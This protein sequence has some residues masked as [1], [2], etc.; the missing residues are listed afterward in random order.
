MASRTDTAATVRI[1][2][3]ASQPIDSMMQRE[4]RS[5]AL[6]FEIVGEHMLK[7]TVT[8]DQLRTL[9]G[10]EWLERVD[11]DPEYKFDSMLRS[12]IVSMR[13]NVSDMTLTVSGK[14]GK[15]ISTELRADLSA[16]GAKIVSTAGDTFN[17]EVT[18]RTLYTMAALDAVTF[19]QLAD[20]E[21]R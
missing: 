6:L 13:R 7:A 10:F 11:I 12:R 9:C 2:G 17:A 3:V 19:V 4:A 18:L 5:F 8:P 15:A 14:C 20:E 16:S 21:P 1:V